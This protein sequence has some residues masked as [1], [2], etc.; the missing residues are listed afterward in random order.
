MLF[1]SVKEL[2]NRGAKTDTVLC[3][4]LRDEKAIRIL[5]DEGLEIHPVFT[6]DYIKKQI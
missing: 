4:V 5:A 6:M 2:R 1:R 3:V